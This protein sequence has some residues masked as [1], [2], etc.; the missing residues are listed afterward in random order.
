[1]RYGFVTSRAFL[2]DCKEKQ[3]AEKAREKVRDV[4]TL[5]PKCLQIELSWQAVGWIQ[6]NTFSAWEPEGSFGT[7]VSLKQKGSV[8]Q[9]FQNG[10]G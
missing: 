10:S 4:P 2:H 7:K 3:K 6:R 1:M 9:H 8:S 5:S